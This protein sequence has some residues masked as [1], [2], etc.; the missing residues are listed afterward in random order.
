MI[1]KRWTIVQLRIS[2]VGSTMAIIMCTISN[3]ICETET[4]HRKK[5]HTY[6]TD[7]VDT[8]H[9]LHPMRFEN[10]GSQPSITFQITLPEVLSIQQ[11]PRPKIPPG[12]WILNV[13]HVY[14]ISV[15]RVERRVT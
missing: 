15:Q 10:F 4:K 5:S 3:L 8:S 14:D 7:P 6:R 12:E 2:A 11:D 9:I 1:G 13:G